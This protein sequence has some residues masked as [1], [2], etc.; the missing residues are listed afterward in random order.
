MKTSQDVRT[1]GLYMSECCGHEQVF[2]EGEV[3]QRCPKCHSLCEWG[4]AEPV[5][6]APEPRRSERLRAN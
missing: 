1:P 3:F 5:A 2:D 6:A 4:L